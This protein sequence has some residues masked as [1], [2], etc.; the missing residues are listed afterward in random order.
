MFLT[1][2]L[3][4]DVGWP[5]LPHPA[6]LEGVNGMRNI[7]SRVFRIYLLFLSNE[8]RTIRQDHIKAMQ[9]MVLCSFQKLTVWRGRRSLVLNEFSFCSGR[10]SSPHKN[11]NTSCYSELGVTKLNLIKVTWENSKC[12]DCKDSEIKV[13]YRYNIKRYCITTVKINNMEILL[14]LRTFKGLFSSF[15]C[16]STCS[17]NICFKFFLAACICN[18]LAGLLIN[19]KTNK[20]KPFKDW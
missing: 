14:S 11:T 18:E 2:F 4:E 19:F 1:L 3:P 13:L 20:H 5:T 8:F 6:H 15:H 12:R 10:D 16:W 17:L 7:Y 9:R